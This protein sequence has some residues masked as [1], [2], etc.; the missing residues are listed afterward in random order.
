MY[1]LFFLKIVE[2]KCVNVSIGSDFINLKLLH[3]E[4]QQASL[5]ARKEL[6]KRQIEL[7]RL[8]QRYLKKIEQLDEKC[9]TYCLKKYKYLHKIHISDMKCRAAEDR[10]KNTDQFLTEYT[11]ELEN[12]SRDIAII[13]EI[14]KNCQKNYTIKGSGKDTISV[15]FNRNEKRVFQKG[16]GHIVIIGDTITYKRPV[17]MPHG[18]QNYVKPTI[19]VSNYF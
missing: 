19:A 1:G 14:P 6:E 9:S 16:H 3:D 4:A 7:P 12:M 5:E 8:E 15:Y 13:L 17:N 10:L 18:S 11:K 2:R